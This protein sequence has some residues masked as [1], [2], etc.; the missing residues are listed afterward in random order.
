[1]LVGPAYNGIPLATATAVAFAVNHLRN[2]PLAYNHK[3]VKA[4]G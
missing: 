2:V 1:M 3:E 4:H